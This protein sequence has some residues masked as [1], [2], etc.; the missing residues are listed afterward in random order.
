VWGGDLPRFTES[1]PK[2]F[3][4]FHQSSFFFV[5]WKTQRNLGSGKEKKKRNNDKYFKCKEYIIIFKKI[6]RKN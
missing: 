2:H 3:V 5:W 4:K 6:K 1:C